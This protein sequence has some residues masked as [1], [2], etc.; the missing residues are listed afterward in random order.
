[1]KLAIIKL[2]ILFLLLLLLDLTR[3]FNYSLSVEF[4]ILGVIFI[5]LTQQFR[6]VLI[7]TLAFGYL[8]D[9]FLAGSAA[10]RIIE[11]PLIGI[12]VYALRSYLPIAQKQKYTL[13]IKYSLV[14]IALIA[15][16]II[17]SVYQGEFFFVFS[18][19]LFIQSYLIYC[20]L[21]YL[22]GTKA[23]AK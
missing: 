1:M 20:F 14:A 10:P 13:L 2:P 3:P 11:Y 18:L 4:I 21:I 8:S 5:A 19:K 23:F 15:H 6:T 22:L 9:L 7:L 12:G 16:I 17:N